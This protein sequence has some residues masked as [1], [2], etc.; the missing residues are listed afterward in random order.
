MPA[1]NSPVNPVQRD[2]YSAYPSYY[3][4]LYGNS[5]SSLF[6]PILTY[7]LYAEGDGR[8]IGEQVKEYVS[9]SAAASAASPG[10]EA[11]IDFESALD[12]GEEEAGTGGAQ[13]ESAGSRR[14]LESLIS[15]GSYSKYGSL[16]GSFSLEPEAAN[17]K[18]M[19]TGAG[20]LLRRVYGGSGPAS[21]AEP[22]WFTRLAEPE[23]EPAFERVL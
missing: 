3:Y 15:S 6:E 12:G 11:D 10:G 20:S 8:W 23:P 16:T 22:G 19:G 21:L 17:A 1:S 14:L 4:P 7:K 13:S 5:P 2:I 9:P 18:V